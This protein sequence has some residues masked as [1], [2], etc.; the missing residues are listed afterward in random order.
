M[1]DLSSPRRIVS[2]GEG[3][4]TW[5]GASFLPFLDCT[6][7]WCG[8]R[9]TPDLEVGLRPDRRGYRVAVRAT[10]CWGW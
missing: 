1:L 3:T 10:M 5:L 2:R 6:A 8:R 9:S 4:N 7:S